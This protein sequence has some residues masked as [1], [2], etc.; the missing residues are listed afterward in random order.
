[1]T[2][3]VVGYRGPSG[4]FYSLRGPSERVRR[5]LTRS[6]PSPEQIEISVL[7]AKLTRQHEMSLLEVHLMKERI[8]D[9]KKQLSESRAER[10]KRPQEV[11]H[12]ENGV[13]VTYG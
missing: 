6:R 5:F 2:G 10:A 9:L 3:K 8:A 4:L 12:Y 11:H 13:R 7:A 1:M